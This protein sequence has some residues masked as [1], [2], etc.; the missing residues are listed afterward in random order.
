MNCGPTKENDETPSLSQQ[1]IYQPTQPGLA[2]MLTV[3]GDLGVLLTYSITQGVLVLSEVLQ[4]TMVLISPSEHKEKKF[5]SPV[6]F[7]VSWL[8]FASFS[9]SCDEP[10]RG[11][12]SR[13]KASSKVWLGHAGSTEGLWDKLGGQL[14]CESKAKHS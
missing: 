14:C 9:V 4:I 8:T 11:L 10:R 1:T 2:L 12:V 6:T 3:T 7:S 5:Y 13:T